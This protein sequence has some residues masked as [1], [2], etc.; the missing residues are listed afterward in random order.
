[1]TSQSELCL[2]LETETDGAYQP[3][4]IKT[5]EGNGVIYEGN[6]IA[7]KLVYGS[8]K[9]S[10]FTYTGD[11]IDYQM[12]GYGTLVYYTHGIHY[13]HGNIVYYT[14]NMVN[15]SFH[16]NG[17]YLDTNGTTFNGHFVHN[18]KHG[19]FTV[20]TDKGQHY[21][22][23]F[24]DNRAMSIE[25]ITTTCSSEMQDTLQFYDSTITKMYNKYSKNKF[26]SILELNTFIKQYP[27]DPVDV[28]VDVVLVDVDASIILPHHFVSVV[29]QMAS[30]LYPRFH[31]KLDLHQS[32][33]L[34]LQAHM[35]TCNK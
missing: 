16:G 34:F 33:H 30:L 11:F 4:N 35:R 15:G 14:G 23:T 7:N 20:T 2:I 22:I 9:T 27:L 25:V 29:C 1:M 3:S 8:L 26:M 31:D 32:L 13:T 5:L 19:L 10:D 12:T 6:W 17:I 18:K 28:L 24:H 21:N